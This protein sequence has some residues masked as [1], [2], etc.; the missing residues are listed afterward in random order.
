MSIHFLVNKM[1]LIHHILTASLWII[2]LQQRKVYRCYQ[3]FISINRIK[4]KLL[5][6]YFEEDQYK[7]YLPGG[8]YQ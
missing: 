4:S 7:I 8:I 5:S 3:I 2:S 6:Y 1:K